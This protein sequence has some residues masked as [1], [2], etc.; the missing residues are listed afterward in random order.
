MRQTA[1]KTTRRE[2][3]KFAAAATALAVIK[4]AALLAEGPAKDAPLNPLKSEK[5]SE[6]LKDIKGTPKEK[7]EQLF[8]L[9]KEKLKTVKSDYDKRPPRTIDETIE[10]GGDCTEFALVVVASLKHL[11]LEGGASL[12]HLKGSAE[13]MDHIVAYAC[14]D[15]T[16]VHIDPQAEKLGVVGEGKGYDPIADLSM[17]EAKGMYY[18]ELGNHYFVKKNYDKSIDAFEQS[19]KFY[20][21]DAYVHHKLGFLYQEKGRKTDKLEYKE[22]S[23]YHHKRSSELAPD[24]EKY[25][26]E[27]ALAGFNYEIKLGEKDYYDGKLPEAKAHFEKA[28]EI[29]KDFI[30]KEEKAVIRQYIEACE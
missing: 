26:K 13:D 6:L 24:N 5:L 25:K 12:V 11:G 19:L 3:I 4:P 18:R 30:T 28:L 29:G 9:L 7:T 27:A 22:K 20:E 14:I 10:K 1:I 8:K 15:E 2:F 17:E 16:K 21:K 23:A